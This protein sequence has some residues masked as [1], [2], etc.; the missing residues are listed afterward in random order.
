[1]NRLPETYLQSLKDIPGMEI[2]SYLDSFEFENQHGLR[3]NN[4]KLSQEQWEKLCKFKTEKVPW[5][6]NGYYYEDAAPARHPHYYAGLYYLQEPSAMTP[7]NRLPVEPGDFVLDLCAAPGGKATELGARLQGSGFLL[8]ND[9]S[10]SRARALLKNLEMAGISNIFVTSETPEKL[11]GYYSGFFD[12]IL[13]DAPCSGEGMFRR[14]PG[15][16]KHWEEQGPAY[17]SKIQTDIVECAYEML[18]PGGMMLYSTCTFSPEEDEKIVLGL[19]QKHPDLDTVPIKAYEG[20]TSGGLGLKDA[21][22]IYPWKMKGEGHFLCLLRKKEGEG[23]A[24]RKELF[25]SAE[26][27]YV[28]LPEAARGFLEKA[29]YGPLKKGSYH[30]I[31]DQIYHLAPGME[32]FK[33]LRYLRT[34]LLLGSMKKNRFEPSQALAMALSSGVFPSVI[35]LSSQ[36][37]R[38]IRYLKGETIFL[39][40]EETHLN[41]KTKKE[42]GISGWVLVCTDGY[43]IGWAKEANG[44]LKNKYNAG[45]RWL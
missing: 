22:R 35:D 40:E 12:K 30:I 44:I 7:A 2:Q 42:D 23:S 16:V 13:V 9:I 29:G 6:E 36:D 34:G 10:N 43:P 25:E 27:S 14:E 24:H 38:T 3:L 8:A 1:M 28:K 5:I 41:N 37:P 31:G 18:R 32:C 17:Y 26:K 33:G 11:K 20:F 19:M 21:V 15:M 39:T 45:W 4:L